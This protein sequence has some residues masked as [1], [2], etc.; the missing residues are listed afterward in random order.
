MSVQARKDQNQIIWK[1]S[2]IEKNN[3]QLH[4]DRR[5]IENSLTMK[6]MDIQGPNMFDMKLK[7]EMNRGM[8]IQPTPQFEMLKQRDQSSYR[9]QQLK[10]HGPSNV[11]EN[12]GA[13]IKNA[14]Y[15]QVREYGGKISSRLGKPNLDLQPVD[16]KESVSAISEHKNGSRSQIRD[17]LLEKMEKILLED[18]VKVKQDDPLAGRSKNLT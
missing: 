16:S 2:A 14:G 9:M 1:K 15:Y 12:K 13:L 17:Q 18:E 4:Q 8:P 6:A 11:Q 3:Q 10:L 5:Q 7:N